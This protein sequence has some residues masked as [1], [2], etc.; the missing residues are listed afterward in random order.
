MH[1]LQFE[2]S[3]ERAQQY[4]IQAIPIKVS[5]SKGPERAQ[6]YLIQ[7]IPI[8]VSISKGLPGHS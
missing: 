8:K 5:I 4:S 6:Q 3:P 1:D 2:T 7:A